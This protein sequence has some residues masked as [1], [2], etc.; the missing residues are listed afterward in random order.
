MRTNSSSHKQASASDQ[1]KKGGRH[2]CVGK[3][4]GRHVFT[5]RLNY[6]WHTRS[7]DGRDYLVTLRIRAN[8]PAHAHEPNHIPRP[9]GAIERVLQPVRR[10]KPTKCNLRNL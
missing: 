10:G 6:R 2:N 8:A 1:P 4:F 7:A 9:I 3:T 5:D